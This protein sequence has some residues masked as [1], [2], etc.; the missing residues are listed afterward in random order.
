MSDEIFTTETSIDFEQLS[1]EV[2]EWSVEQFGADQPAWYAAKGAV[3]ECGELIHSDLKRD[4]GIRLDDDDVGN[5]AERDAVG[6]IVIYLADAMY[7]AEKTVE[8]WDDSNYSQTKDGALSDVARHTSTLYNEMERGVNQE[9]WDNHVK[10]IVGSL[11][12]YCDFNEYDFGRCVYEAWNGEV[13]DREWDAEITH[14]D[15]E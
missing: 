7:R 9:I 10:E 2:G 14:G 15:S 4:Q 3:E 1:Q 12:A 8:L 13:S 6:D 11:K 5:D